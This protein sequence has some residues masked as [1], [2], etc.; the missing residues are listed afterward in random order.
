MTEGKNLFLSLGQIDLMRDPSGLPISGKIYQRIKNTP[1]IHTVLP[2]LWMRAEITYKFAKSV[3][4]AGIEEV[5]SKEIAN[6][7][8]T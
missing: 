2:L 1:G 8:P 3:I 7:F 6:F 4:S 5:V